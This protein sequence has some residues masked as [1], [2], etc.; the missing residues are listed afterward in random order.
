MTNTK[1][2]REITQNTGL[3]RKDVV[4]VLDALREAVYVHIEDR[5]TIA[6]LCTFKV[7]R[8]AARMGRNPKTGEAIKIKAKTVP[9]ILPAKPLK[10][11]VQ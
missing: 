2:I 3:K 1:L 6:G 10:D 4:A 7:L 11:S 8:R 5:V 9:R